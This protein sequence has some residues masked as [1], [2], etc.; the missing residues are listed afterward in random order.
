MTKKLKPELDVSLDWTGGDIPA[1]GSVTV[2]IAWSPNQEISCKDSL[3]LTDDRHFRKDVMFIFKSI[4]R[5][6]PPKAV[7]KKTTARHPM[8]TVHLV[9]KKPKT[10]F[11][12]HHKKIAELPTVPKRRFTGVSRPCEPQQQGFQFTVDIKESN[13]RP[14]LAVKS[15]FREHNAVS[16]R[17]SPGDVF[18]YNNRN[19]VTDKEN[20]SPSSPANAS[21]LFDQI[22]FTPGSVTVARPVDKKAMRNH[23]EYLA[24]LPTPTQENHHRVNL[25]ISEEF[26]QQS[27]ESAI[28]I[29]IIETPRLVKRNTSDASMLCTLDTPAGNFT[30]VASSTIAIENRV[31]NGNDTTIPEIDTSLR[32]CLFDEHP[33]NK[34]FNVRDR[35]DSPKISPYRQT[36]LPTSP[37][38]GSLR[39]PSPAPSLCM[40]PEEDFT[41]ERSACI[42]KTF[43]I[44]PVAAAAHDETASALLENI[45]LVGTPLRKKFQSMRDLNLVQKNGKSAA[46]KDNQGSMPNLHQIVKMKPIENNRYFYQSLERDHERAQDQES[47]QFN[48]SSTS[49]ASVQFRETEILAQSSQ[50]NIN[51]CHEPGSATSSGTYFFDG[52]VDNSS[53]STKISNFR[54]PTSVASLKTHTITKRVIPRIERTSPSPKSSLSKRDRDESV[55]ARRRI[56]DKFSPPKRARIDANSSGYH[57]FRSSSS[58]PQISRKSFNTSMTNT[59]SSFTSTKNNSSKFK[60]PKFPVQKLTLKRQQPEERVFLYDA[61]IHIQ[62]K[63]LQFSC[64]S[65]FNAYSHSNRR[66]KSRS[67]CSHNNV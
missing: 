13:K 17:M 2:E 46:L 25:N 29:H 38:I 34:T 55:A 24:S 15:P 41:F 65:H 63:L 48:S 32:R 66:D 56:S 64:A 37:S 36:I 22:C 16:N 10:N 54:M 60:M 23:E 62:G 14:V 30:N 47:Q 31:L 43:N 21:A 35:Q 28:Q 18:A 52:V 67:I 42:Q 49:V 3:Q 59:S 50:F 61:E 8:T 20:H 44:S 11:S 26:M 7:L 58:S 12:P 57:L 9:Q 45:N 6:K 39:C 33:P 51:R 27:F 5:N 4:D 53:S 1:S 19:T 40:I